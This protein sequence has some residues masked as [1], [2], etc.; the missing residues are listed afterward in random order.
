MFLP[1][2]GPFERFNLNALEMYSFHCCNVLTGVLNSLIGDY[3]VAFNCN[4]FMPKNN[5]EV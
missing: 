3:S 5:V 4:F 1:S 2:T